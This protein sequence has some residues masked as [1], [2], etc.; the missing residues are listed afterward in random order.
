MN[1]LP[2]ALVALLA[3]SFVPV[4]M[5][6]ATT[7]P[8]AVPP[9]VATMVSNF[10]LVVFAA[11]IVVGTGQRVVPHLSSPKMWHTLGAGLFL[12]IGILAYYRALS[13]GPVS[14][15]TP[16]FGM[17]LVTS[18]II[19]IVALGEPLTRRKLLGIGLAIIAVYL[20]VVE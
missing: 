15:V 5:R 12:G 7:G 20:V 2:W 1:Y 4:L 9:D 19:G 3:Y 6:V 18:S 11:A 16:I 10:V 13:V 14:V 17:F 8:E